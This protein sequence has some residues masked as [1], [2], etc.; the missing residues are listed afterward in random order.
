MNFVRLLMSWTIRFC[1][2]LV[3]TSLS[4]T[5]AF[6]IWKVWETYMEKHGKL[7]W[8]YPMLAVVELF[9]VLPLGYGA[10]VLWRSG[11]GW[12]DAREGYLFKSTGVITIVCTG[13]AVIWIAGVLRY[14]FKFMYKV[15]RVNYVL[16]KSCMPG[17]P[18][19]V[20]LAGDIRRKLGIRQRVLVCQS[21]LIRVPVVANGFRKRIIFPV[22][23]FDRQEAEVILSHEL[24]HVK[25]KIL[26]LKMIGFVARMVYW[27]NP[28]AHAFMHE[29]DDWG[30]IACDM[31]VRYEAKCVE[32]FREYFG[33]ILESVERHREIPDEWTQL[34]KEK[35]VM[36][37]V[38]RLRD[39]KKE[40]DWKL[41]GGIVAMLVFCLTCTTTVAAAGIGIGNGYNKLYRSTVDN[42]IEVYSPADDGLVM[43]EEE[44]DPSEHDVTV[45]SSGQ[46]ARGSGYIGW[47]VPSNKVYCSPDFYASGSIITVSVTCVPDG[48]L[49]NAG[50]LTPDGKRK[51][52]QVTGSMTYDFTISVSGYYC[53]FVENLSDTKLTAT[54]HYVY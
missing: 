48:K 13:L 18:T 24:I 11:E 12:L 37:R 17:E 54:G 10:V 36:R 21:Y 25:Q 52:V 45:V 30:E 49:Y 42:E 4:G 9:F 53:A 1:I 19:L 15:F 51:Y 39:Y 38:M 44:W 14:F 23:E 26:P 22:G 16:R 35:G 33:L 32:D 20:L 46:M 40:N 7:Q 50:V 5:I 28:F 41:A 43:Y 29:L 34:A 31:A 2:T 47:Y 3:L 8:I 6:L 27:F